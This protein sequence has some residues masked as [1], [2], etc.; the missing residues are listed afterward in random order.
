MDFDLAHSTRQ[1]TFQLFKLTY[2]LKPNS[3]LIIR[4]IEIYQ[5]KTCHLNT[6]S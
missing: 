6:L 2:K 5:L 1:N 4:L 3:S